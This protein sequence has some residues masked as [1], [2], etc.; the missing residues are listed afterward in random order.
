MTYALTAGSDFNSLF[1]TQYVRVKVIAVTSSTVVPDG[2]L[3]RKSECICFTPGL[4]GFETLIHSWSTRG[5]AGAGRYYGIAQHDAKPGQT[6]KV[7]VAGCGLAWVINRDTIGRDVQVA[8]SSPL[9]MPTKA[10]VGGEAVVSAPL[11]RAIDGDFACAELPRA[12][13]GVGAGAENVQLELVHLHPGYTASQVDW[14]TGLRPQMPNIYWRVQNQ[15]GSALEV[16]KFYAMETGDGNNNPR[17]IVNIS[18]SSAAINSDTHGMVGMALIAAAAND[19]TVIKVAGNDTAL[20]GGSWVAGDTG[21]PFEVDATGRVVQHAGSQKPFGWG[22][23]NGT[24][25]AGGS[26]RVW[27]NGISGV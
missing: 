18:T 27:F 6:V 15:T 9:A 11:H 20:A 19:Y 5:N 2:G 12:A 25:A 4:E 23:V 22:F 17:G 13:D 21:K 10:T 7:M 24:V 16:G 1:A 14:G 3:V 8:G 26:V